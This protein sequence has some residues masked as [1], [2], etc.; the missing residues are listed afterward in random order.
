MRGDETC[1]ESV[2]ERQ[3]EALDLVRMHMG[4]RLICNVCLCFVG[5]GGNAIHEYL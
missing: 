4:M 2:A 1:V 3:R 5:T